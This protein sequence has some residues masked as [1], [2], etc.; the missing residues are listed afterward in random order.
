MLIPYAIEI[1]TMSENPASLTEIVV[2]LMNPAAYN[3]KSM[4]PKQSLGQNFLLNG[5]IA[6]RIVASA[7]VT[8]DETVLEVGPGLGIL[9]ALLAREAKQLIAVEKDDDLFAVLIRKFDGFNNLRL[10][11]ADILD[12]DL[13][14]LIPEK[15]KL[16][17]NLPYNIA[18]QL[19]IRLIEHARNLTL[20][21]VMVQKEVGQRIC[22]Q[23]GTHAYSALSV[24][25]DSVFQATPG[26]IVSP[27]NFSPQPKVDSMVLKLTPKLDPINS[28]DMAYF[29]KSVYCAFA[30]RRKMLKNSLI[31]LPMLKPHLLQELAERAGI[32]LNQRPQ[33][34][35]SQDFY[36]IAQAY[37]DF[38]IDI[39]T[40]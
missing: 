19:I 2:L 33:N 6:E 11:H 4:R 21:V 3:D 34:L 12:L 15:T 27:K 30:Q 40:V 17:A 31:N 7:C 25:V 36:R 26:F 24:L 1:R 10:V 14:E 37:Q 20:V 16:V 5:Q 29:K 35:T 32:K 39:Q 22:A 38:I 13:N 23:P 9:T 18:S 28:R 8:P